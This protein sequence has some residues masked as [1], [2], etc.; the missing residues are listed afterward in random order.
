MFHVALTF[1]KL[2]V[3]HL[4]EKVRKGMCSDYLS[5]FSFTQNFHSVNSFAKTDLHMTAYATLESSTR[6]C[7][8]SNK[9]AR[10]NAIIYRYRNPGFH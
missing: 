4:P 6:N 5:E 8:I 3:Y 7:C 2:Y 9:Q 1:E 10:L